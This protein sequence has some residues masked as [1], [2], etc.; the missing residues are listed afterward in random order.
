MKYHINLFRPPWPKDRRWDK[1]QNAE[2]LN[3]VFTGGTFGNFLKFFLDKFSTLTPN[4]DVDPFWDTGILHRT[5]ENVRFSGLIQ[6]YHQSFINDNEGNIDLPICI[7]TP[8]MKK[9]YLYLK[10]AQL[11][12][13]ANLRISPDDLWKMSVPEMPDE[14]KG[15]ALSIKKLYDIHSNQLPKFI[16]RDWYKLGFLKNIKDTYDYQWFDTFKN[17]EFFEKQKVFN[18]DLETFFDWDTFD[19]NITE[20]DKFFGLCLDFDRLAEMK[21]LFDRGLELDSIRK[22]CNKVQSVVE[23]GE[24]EL[25]V[26]LDVSSEA[27]I[28]SELERA[29]PGIL[30]PLSN[31]FFKNTKEIK[32]F[33]EHFP[34]WYS[35]PNPNLG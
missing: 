12:R 16:V 4:I 10:K 13:A 22:E 15:H 6:R 35:I 2:L 8:S 34:N 30:L 25:P 32:Q 18:L 3:I 27:F 28:Y 1:D 31:N 5:S 19:K 23:L 33:I 11:F 21:S 29:N 7:I 17:H 20:L 26:E 24:E 9:H 14:I